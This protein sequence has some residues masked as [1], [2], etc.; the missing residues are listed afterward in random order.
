MSRSYRLPYVA[1]IGL[2]ILLVGREVA[3]AKDIPPI[4]EGGQ[5]IQA[6]PEREAGHDQEPGQKATWPADIEAG[7]EA[8]RAECGTP[9]SC[10]AE[11]REY[12]DLRAQWQ[13]AEASRGQEWF[14]LWQTIIAAVATGVAGIGTLFLIW[15][16]RENRRSAD[17]AVAAAKAAEDANRIN[18]QAYIA[19]QR[20]WLAINFKLDGPLTCS[21]N[22]VTLE[23]LFRIR[24]VGKSPAVM[25][26]MRTELVKRSDLSDVQRRQF[27]L[28]E[29]I[30]K[31]GTVHIDGRT[32][33]P[34]SYI[35]FARQIT[36]SNDMFMYIIRNQV[37]ISYRLPIIIGSVSYSPTSGDVMYQ[38]GFIIEILRLRDDGDP[39]DSMDGLQGIPANRLIAIEFPAY[40]RVT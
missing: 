40:P 5:A 23:L 22:D 7:E 20:P 25:A 4:P 28:T 17:A 13:A 34:G 6:Q 29:K 36:A 15:T 24:N 8:S 21:E 27:F 19:D 35:E 18:W 33:F 11:Q 39:T 14:A 12:S 32:I 31:Q 10:R 26:R 1:A 30:E 9:E 2:L 38:T 37:T 16:F 3:Q